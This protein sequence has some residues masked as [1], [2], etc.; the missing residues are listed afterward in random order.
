M[1]MSSIRSYN[2]GAVPS[3]GVRR[4]CSCGRVNIRANHEPARLP[5]GCSFGI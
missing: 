5:Y 1:T 2:S 4:W 3:I